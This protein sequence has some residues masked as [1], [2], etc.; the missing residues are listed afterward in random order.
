MFAGDLGRGKG[1]IGELAG[2]EVRGGPVGVW[3]W[4]RPFA[5]RNGFGYGPFGGRVDARRWWWG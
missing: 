5:K 2:D 3:D 4:T 1:A